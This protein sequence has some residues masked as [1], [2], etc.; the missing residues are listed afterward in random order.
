M[1]SVEKIQYLPCVELLLDNFY[2][3]LLIFNHA[4]GYTI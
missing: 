4:H 3:I 2:N 1:W